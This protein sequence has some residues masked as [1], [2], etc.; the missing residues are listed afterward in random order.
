MVAVKIPVVTGDGRRFD[1]D[2]ED[3]VRLVLLSEA[4]AEIDP[5][6]WEMFAAPVKSGRRQ[7]RDIQTT[8][9]TTPAPSP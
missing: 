9:P 5:Q 4:C 6:L 1:L 3:Y 2:S 8:R 7:S